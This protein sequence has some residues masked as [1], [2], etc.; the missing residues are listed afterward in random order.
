MSDS[1]QLDILKKLTVHLQGIIPA[2]GYDFDMSDSVFR[3]RVIYGDDDPVPL[4]NVVEHLSADVSVETAAENKIERQETWILLVQGWLNHAPINPT[5][6]AY[7]LKAAVEHR[8]ARLVKIDPSNGDPLYPDEYF[9]GI[10][11]TIT[12][13]SIGPGV[14]S[15]ATRESGSAK[16]FFY[17]PVGITLAIDVSDPF[18]DA[19]P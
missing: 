14:V 18:V 3:G 17:L 9:L 2:N 4:I 16:A 10:V 19:V 13:I 5:D 15:T 12:G 6:D 7:Q 1:R 11:D 8:L